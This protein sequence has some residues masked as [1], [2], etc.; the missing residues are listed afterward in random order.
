MSSGRSR[1]GTSSPKPRS[2]AS[3]ST[4]RDQYSETLAEVQTLMA[5]TL[6]DLE[7]SGTTSSGSTSMR[8]PSP[9]HSG[10][11]PNEAL[12]END[13]GSSSSMASGWSLGH[14]SRSEKRLDSPESTKSAITR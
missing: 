4:S 14:E 10:Q 7:S 8:E 2:S 12:K 13:R 11:A 5:P 9:W 3:A 6:M 1:Y